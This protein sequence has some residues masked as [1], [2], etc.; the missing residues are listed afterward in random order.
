[1]Q[2]T[3]Q[4][5]VIDHGEMTHQDA[6]PVN[7]EALMRVALDKGK[8]G[9][10]ILERLLVMRRELNAEAAKKAFD[11]SLAAFQASCPTIIKA[12]A[13]MNK[14]GRSIRYKYAPLD[15]I[16]SQ[17]KDCLM[18]NG[19][20]YS[21]DT[22]VEAGWVRAICKITH[23]GGHSQLSEFKVPIDAESYMTD[24]QKYASALTFAKRYAFCG[25]FGILT[26]DEDT[27]GRGERGNEKGPSVA[28]AQKPA[29]NPPADKSS[30]A[31]LW[32]LTQTIHGGTAS[33]LE[34]RLWDECLLDPSTRLSDIPAEQMP[35]IVT[36][37]RKKLQ[38]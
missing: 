13:V 15:S 21:I 8:D 20:S 29:S 1:M 31:E 5:T 26:S 36:Q 7:V 3:E 35:A 14:D 9:V 23:R 28:S 17:V 37:A 34:Q 38:R 2:N 30:K 18:S 11:E 4:M 25:G 12:K 22:V 10:E 6:M 16:V 27:D 32:R 33:V 19:F 24:Q